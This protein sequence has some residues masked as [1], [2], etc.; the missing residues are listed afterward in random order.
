LNLSSWVCLFGSVCLGLSIWVCLSGSVYLGLSIWVSLFGS[1][2]LG[3]SM[4]VCLDVSV[5]V[6]ECKFWFYWNN[7]LLSVS[8][9]YFSILYLFVFVSMLVVPLERLRAVGEFLLSCVHL[10]PRGTVGLMKEG[11]SVGLI[12]QLRCEPHLLFALDST[13][14]IL[15]RDTYPE[16]RTHRFIQ[17]PFVTTYWVF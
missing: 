9:Y 10:S 6:F 11:G 13:D 14:S 1:V 8:S 17:L 4:W 5:W 15:L 7:R 12:P 2:Y 16:T 3:L